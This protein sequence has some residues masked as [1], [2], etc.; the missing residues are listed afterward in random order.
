M[1][2]LI[3]HINN[4]PIYRK[5]L[6]GLILI[7]FA[8][9]SCVDEYWPQLGDNY[10][11]ALVVEGSITNI[12]GPYVVRLSMTARPD[13][14]EYRPLPGY[15]VK[16]MDD[17]G[18]EEILMDLGEGSYVSRWN[19]I[20]GIPGRS[21]KVLITSPEGK[22]Y[23]SSYERMAEP[24]GIDTV[25]AEYETRED[26][27]FDHMLEGYQ[28]YISTKPSTEDTSYFLWRLTGTYKYMANHNIRYIYDGT[29]RPFSNWDS[30]KTCWL[31]YNV[32]EIFTHH[33]LYLSEPYLTGYPLHFVNTEDKKLSIRYS[34]LTEQYTVSKKAHEFW[35]SLKEQ[36]ND[37]G[38]L[39]ATLP[40]QIRGNIKSVTNPEEPALGYFMTASVTYNRTFVNRPHW[41]KFHYPIACYLITEGIGDLLQ[42]MNNQWPVYL[43]TSLTEEGVLTIAL[44]SSQTCVDCTKSGGTITEPGFWIN[45]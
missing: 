32:P 11:A 22:E 7:G 15:T 30:L 25:W 21:Y 44:P 12:P 13:N 10:E 41:A 26:L 16:I 33:T 42:I 5:S 31:T 38:S 2:R 23:E 1:I 36:A 29:L 9:A 4:L 40:Y 19:G 27:N 8:M 24:V 35:K 28:F 14:K 3:R 39:Y 20:Q 17:Q 37:Q 18:N 6:A 45:N 34:L 43:T